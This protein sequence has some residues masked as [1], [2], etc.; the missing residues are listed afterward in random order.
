MVGVPWAMAFVEEQQIMEM[1]RTERARE[2]AGE[3]CAWFF[4][5]FLS[6]LS[7]FSRFLFFLSKF[8]AFHSLFWFRTGEWGVGVVLRVELHVFF[9]LGSLVGIL[10]LWP[11][12]GCFF[13]VISSKLDSVVDSA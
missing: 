11:K 13:G 6:S 3:V 2:V 10:L 7:L 8:N 5:S 4:F 9:G 12:S 1:E